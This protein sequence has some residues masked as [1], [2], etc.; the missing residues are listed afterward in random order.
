MKKKYYAPAIFT[1]RVI[2]SHDTFAVLQIIFVA[3][4]NRKCEIYGNQT[5]INDEIETIHANDN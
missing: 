4:Q 2:F 5:A 3:I 1:V